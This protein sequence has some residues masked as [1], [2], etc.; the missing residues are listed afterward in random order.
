MLLVLAEG[1]GGVHME[2]H[3]AGMGVLGASRKG[4]CP[5]ESTKL[6]DTSCDGAL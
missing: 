1:G 6:D 2:L 5:D 4:V 3:G